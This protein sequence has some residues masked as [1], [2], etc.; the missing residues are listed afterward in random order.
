MIY[1]KPCQ[2]AFYEGLDNNQL[3]YAMRYSFEKEDLIYRDFKVT[4]Q[5]H[6]TDYPIKRII[7]ACCREE[8][9]EKNQGV[10]SVSMN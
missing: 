3:Y 9:F 4:I 6:H 8:I 2:A 5:V 1:L 10:I 7:N